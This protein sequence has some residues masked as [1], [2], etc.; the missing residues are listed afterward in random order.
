MYNDF[1]NF[2]ENPFS[3]T[4]DPHFFFSSSHHTEA[5]SHLVY[6]I[7]QRKG[8]ILVT[9]EIG[10]GKTTICR[11]L[12]SRLGETT[13]TALILNPSF[14][15]LQLLQFILND[16]GILPTA[17]NKF[18][19]ISTLNT[20]LLEQT[21]RGNNV[22]LIIDEAQNLSVR[23]LEQIRLLS[24]LETEKQKLLQIVLMGQPELCQKLKL[25]ALRQLNQRIG[26]RFHLMPL[27]KEDINN[28]IHHR[29]A[30]ATGEAK[31]QNSLSFTNKALNR[32]FEISEGTPRVINIICD[33]ALLAG[34][35]HELETIDEDI[36]LQCAREVKGT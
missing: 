12:L 35:A 5:I 28:Y 8:I 6:G 33:R 13:K 19:L 32:I 26:V 2:Q 16:Y 29:I 25:P 27:T 15:D 24:N 22:V 18:S 34:F 23:Q 21:T 31:N 20:F 9:G 17:K 36:I 10:T 1:Y 3:I 11:T 30:V 14:S 7:E 4:P